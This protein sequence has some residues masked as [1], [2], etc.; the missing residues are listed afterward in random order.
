MHIITAA[1]SLG[2]VEECR[3]QKL[4]YHCNYPVYLLEYVSVNINMPKVYMA[5]NLALFSS[6]SLW[7]SFQMLDF[8]SAPY[9]GA[10]WNGDWLRGLTRAI[11][12]CILDISVFQ[13]R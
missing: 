4:V 12:S 7:E 2:L 13:R 1:Y 6:L 9:L 3:V 8:C 11:S 5:L 10:T